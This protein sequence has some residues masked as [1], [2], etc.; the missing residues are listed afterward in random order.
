LLLQYGAKLRSIEDDEAEFQAAA[1]A[2]L[3]Q[4]SALSPA[5]QATVRRY[6]LSVGDL[7]PERCSTM[8]I[9][10]Q[11]SDAHGLMVRSWLKMPFI[12]RCARGERP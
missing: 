9:Q 5:R 2:V 7:Q 10:L 8:H 4:W 11:V 1:N 6:D 12:S 3:R